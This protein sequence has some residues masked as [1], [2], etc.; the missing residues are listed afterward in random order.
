M[1]G[2]AV[3]LGLTYKVAE[4]AVEHALREA[5]SMGAL[6]GMFDARAIGVDLLKAWLP[7]EDPCETCRINAEQGPI[8]LELP[9]ASGHMTPPACLKCRCA[10]LPHV[11][12]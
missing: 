7:A 11:R 3:A 2:D 9:F 12:D 4:M 8:A 1:I 10:L 6:Q 5:N